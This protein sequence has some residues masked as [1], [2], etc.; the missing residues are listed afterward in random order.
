MQ[1]KLEKIEQKF[2]SIAEQTGQLIFDGDAR[3]GKIEWAGAIEEFT[4]YTP[5]EFSKV[6][7]NACRDIIHP[8][9]RER[10]WG[11]LEKSLKKGEAFNQ[12]FRFKRKDGSYIYVED[13]SVF[14]KDEDNRIYRAIGLLKD[15]TE[16]QNAQDKLRTKEECLLKYLQNFRGIGFQLDNNFYLMLLHGAVKEITGYESKEFLSGKIRWAQLVDPEDLSHFLENR[17]KLDSVANHLVEH[18]YRVR[19]KDGNRV[20]V[21]ESIQIVHNTDDAPCLYQGFIRDITE[22]KITEEALE[23]LEKLRK[24]EIHHRIKNNLQVISSLLD[25][26]CEN[27]LSGGFDREKIVK[28]F[29]ESHDRIV[30]MSIIHEELYKSS[31]METIDFASYLRKLTADLLRSYKVGASNVRLRLD[32]EDLFLEME[33]AIPLGIIVNELVSNSLKHAFPN[34]KSG[35]IRIELS[36]RVTGSN[37]ILSNKITDTGIQYN[38]YTDRYFTLIVEDNGTGFPESV[39]FRNTSSLGLQLVNTLVDQIGASIQLEKGQGAKFKIRVT[40]F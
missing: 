9:D 38:S 1:T 12:D 33:R 2:F 35:E 15:V 10:V 14:L 11:A 25:L 3:T 13:S 40:D 34:G 23:R 37:D 36:L 5:E 16:R 26:E 39:D 19:G 18:E 6:D 22:I 8:E 20:W 30:S 7:L 17:R 32:M 24:K 27:L 4:G 21:F 28:A 31:D 29:R